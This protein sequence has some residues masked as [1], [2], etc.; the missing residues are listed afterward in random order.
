MQ[1]LW[2]APTKYTEGDKLVKLDDS[3]KIEALD[4]STSIPGDLKEAIQDAENLIKTD[5][6]TALVVD[7]DALE[8]QAKECSNTIKRLTLKLSQSGGG[9]TKR[10]THADVRR[11]YQ[12]RDQEVSSI[13]NE[14]NK[15]HDKRDESYKL[16]IKASNEDATLTAP[17]TLGLLRGL[18]TFTQ[19]VYMTSPVDDKDKPT[20]YIRNAPIVI[21]DKPAYPIRG[22]LLDTARNY[23]PLRDIKRTLNAMSYSKMN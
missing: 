1:A 13:A 9:N 23:Y 10:A 4:L 17:T 15:A 12:K 22:L 14:I 19:L 5:N 2:P 3:F 20:H 8:K 16:E 18:Q 11:S 21:D 7:L 6:M